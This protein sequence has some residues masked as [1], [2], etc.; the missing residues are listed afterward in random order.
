MEQNGEER[1]IKGRGGN[2][3]GEKQERK[4]SERTRLCW[5]GGNRKTK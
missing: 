5:R 2:T 1:E 4:K 3:E